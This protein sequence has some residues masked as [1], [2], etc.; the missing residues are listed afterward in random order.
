MSKKNNSK[1][2]P[3]YKDIP[4][5]CGKKFFGLDKETKGLRAELEEYRKTHPKPWYL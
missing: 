1:Q 4:T 2:E 3:N 5:N